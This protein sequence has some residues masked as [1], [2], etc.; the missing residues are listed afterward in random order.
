M[1]IFGQI[2]EVSLLF[3]IPGWI[4]KNDDHDIWEALIKRGVLETYNN[5]DFK[6]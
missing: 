4:H 3:L 1:I 2:I 5:Q 6:I